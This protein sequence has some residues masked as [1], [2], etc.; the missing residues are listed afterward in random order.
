M[1][2]IFIILFALIL[3]F[4]V[5]AQHT[6]YR[7]KKRLKEREQILQLY[8]TNHQLTEQNT[9][10]PKK[11]HISSRDD[12]FMQKIMQEIER[13]MDNDNYSIDTMAS[14]IG[15]SRTLLLKRI[16]E[17]TGSTPV[18]FRSRP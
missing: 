4:G 9:F 5:Y 8:C 3:I 17:L 10:E 13:N 18:E 16:K 2:T 11:P 7:L 6:I 1:Q 12:D 14:T 15:V